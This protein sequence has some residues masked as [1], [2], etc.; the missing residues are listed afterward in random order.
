MDFH[1]VNSAY[2]WKPMYIFFM[3]RF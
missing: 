3:A 2:M 1:L